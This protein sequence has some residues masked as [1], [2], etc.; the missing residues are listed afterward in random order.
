M[1]TP[2]VDRVISR[3]RRAPRWAWEISI[4]TAITPPL[5]QVVAMLDRLPPA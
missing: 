5:L 4:L 2:F 1:N 3:I